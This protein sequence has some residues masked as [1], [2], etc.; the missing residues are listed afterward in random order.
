MVHFSECTLQFSIL[1]TF[2]FVCRP[3]VATHANTGI[4]LDTVIIRGEKKELER[5]MAIIDA[6]MN[7]W[8]RSTVVCGDVIRLVIIKP[9]LVQD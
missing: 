6:V 1:E 3:K 4:I 9:A 8:H 7:L 2:T 5:L